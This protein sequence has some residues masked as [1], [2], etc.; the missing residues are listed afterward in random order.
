MS[1]TPTGYF[2]LSYIIY[3]FNVVLMHVNK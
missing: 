2:K 3:Y 1:Q